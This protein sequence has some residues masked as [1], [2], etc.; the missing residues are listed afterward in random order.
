[1]MKDSRADAINLQ[2]G[3]DRVDIIRAVSAA[4]IPVM[5]HVGLLPH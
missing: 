4:G 3:K 1:M 2:C 5:S